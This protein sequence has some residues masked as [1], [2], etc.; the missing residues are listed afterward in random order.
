MYEAARVRE[1]DSGRASA[2]RITEVATGREVVTIEQAA[3]QRGIT[4]NS[5]QKDITRRKRRGLI[6]ELPRLN[7]KAP[8]YYPEEVRLEEQ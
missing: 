8:V 2:Y 4:V 5:M 3:A 7:G 1:A 6:T